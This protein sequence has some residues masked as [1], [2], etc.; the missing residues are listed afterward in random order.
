MKSSRTSGQKESPW[1]RVIRARQWSYFVVLPLAAQPEPSW[2][3][4][5]TVLL[6]FAIAG[7]SLAFAYAINAI[8]D[9]ATDRDVDKNPLVGSAEVASPVH[10]M[11]WLLPILALAAAWWVGPMTAAAAAASLLAGWLYSGPLRLKQFPV[12]GL[13]CN[14][15]IFVPLLFLGG[16]WDHAGSIAQ[17]S[18]VIGFGVLLTQNQL[19][20]E[21]ADRGEA[22]LAGDRTTAQWR[23]AK[24]TR[25][26]CIALGVV[27]AS[28]ALFLPAFLNLAGCA[29]LLAAT[30]AL[31]VYFKDPRSAR[32]VHRWVCLVGGAAY[33]L[34]TLA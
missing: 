22:I 6:C 3:V 25:I 10:A 11:L 8:A 19:F 24:S 18:I 32:R 27:G 34:A 12:V 33:Y 15:G 9:S 29:L 7:C 20:H 5:G 1:W 30:L 26:L 16:T 2:Q 13:F 17:L 28:A 21:L 4:A 31:V 14:H 23:G